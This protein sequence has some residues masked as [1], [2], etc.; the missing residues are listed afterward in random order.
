MEL[1]NLIKVIESQKRFRV[2]D[3]WKTELGV[4]ESCFTEDQ[5]PTVYRHI[6]SGN[7][8]YGLI[9]I[10][11]NVTLK[12]RF[13]DQSTLPRDRVVPESIDR[14]DVLVTHLKENGISYT[15][16]SK[17]EQV[18]FRAAKSLLPSQLS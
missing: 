13:V 18:I 3:E 17:F 8:S 15:P 10:S 7:A 11:G 2:E 6:K 4:P 5:R 12:V 9:D 1:S 16:D 14:Y